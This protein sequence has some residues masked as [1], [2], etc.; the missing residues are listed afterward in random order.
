MRQAGRLEV[1][2]TVGRVRAG[3]VGRQR[4]RQC[5]MT[6]RLMKSESELSKRGNIAGGDRSGHRNNN[7]EALAE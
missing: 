4:S 1:E 6:G 7:S 2:H 5:W 3:S